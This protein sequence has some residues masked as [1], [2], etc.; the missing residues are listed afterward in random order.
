MFE[1]PAGF[2]DAEWHQD[3]TGDTGTDHVLHPR[4]YVITCEWCPGIFFA[5]TKRRAM[6]LL[7]RH[8]DDWYNRYLDEGVAAG[9]FPDP[10]VP[11]SRD[12]G[13]E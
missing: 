9:H 13:R 11:A 5:P 2:S 8:R 4:Q 7:E 3:A 6:A 1:P 10:R 12:S